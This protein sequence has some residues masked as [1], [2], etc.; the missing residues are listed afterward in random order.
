[1]LLLDVFVWFLCDRVCDNVWYVHFVLTC[2]VFY[3][4][5][6][7]CVNV[8][9]CI[10]CDLMCN[11]VWF[12]WFVLLK[13]VCDISLNV[14]VRYVCDLPY[15]VISCVFVLCFVVVERALCTCNMFVCFVCD[16]LRE[17]VC[18][19]VCVVFVVCIMCVLCDCA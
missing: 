8:F 5:V 2:C 7:V 6:A 10:V 12:V 3:V 16:A 14:L 4:C 19:C 15:D 1:M 9:E 11:G 17:F 13:C 18:V